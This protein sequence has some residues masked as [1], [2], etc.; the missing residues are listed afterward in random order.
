MLAADG[1]VGSCDGGFDVAQRGVD[2]FE[3]WRPSRPWPR[4]GLDDLVRAPSIGDAGETLK[5]TTEQSG[6]RL[7]LANPA[8]EAA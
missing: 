7:R 5:A 1:T 8:I 3:G 2:P 4:P 6:S